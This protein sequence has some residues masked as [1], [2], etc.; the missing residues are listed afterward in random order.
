MEEKE[1]EAGE[2]LS[3]FPLFFWDSTTHTSSC[4]DALNCQRLKGSE[5]LEPPIINIRYQ[6]KKFMVCLW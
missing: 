6:H 3:T 5:G 1:D 4:G 2:D